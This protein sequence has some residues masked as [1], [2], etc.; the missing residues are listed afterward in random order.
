MSSGWE[1]GGRRA[2]L[3]SLPS[4]PSD[5]G[6]G[7]A[8]VVMGSARCLPPLLPFWSAPC[9][10]NKS[11]PA[12][13]HVRPLPPPSPPPPTRANMRTPAPHTPASAAADAPP[14]AP[15]KRAAEDDSGAGPT[16]RSAKTPKTE[17]AAKGRA[18]RG[19]KVR[20][21]PIYAPSVHPLTRARATGE[22]RRVLVQGARAAAAPQPHPHPAHTRG[23]RHGLAR[24]DRPRL[25][26][27]V[28]APPQHVRDRQLRLEGQQAPHHRAP[29]PRGRRGEGEGPCYAY[30][31]TSR[32]C[33]GAA[34]GMLIG[35]AWVAMQDQ[36]DRD[37]QQ[38]REGRRRRGRSEGRGC[39]GSR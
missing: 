11:S 10:L 19:P 30:V 8:H 35:P 6:R 28:H 1:D 18:K 36:R 31:R 9:Q 29:E 24:V 2:G 16:T 39:R 34:T 37:R 4:G 22:P 20:L 33:G 23:R 3:G 32:R 17:K 13:S 5:S 21:G 26:R 15:R 12:H 14:T 25:P 7:R 38:G 27:H